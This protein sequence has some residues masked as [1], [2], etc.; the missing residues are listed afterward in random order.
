[1]ARPRSPT[2]RIGRR[3]TRSIHA[4]AGKVKRM[5]GRNS[6]VPSS[7]NWKASTWRT[8]AA[9]NGIAN[10]LICDPKTLID[11]A[12]HSLRKLAWRQRDEPAIADAGPRG[13]LGSIATDTARPWELAGPI[14]RGPAGGWPARSRSF[15][16]EA[17]F[18]DQLAM[19]IT[20]RK[21]PSLMML[22]AP[23]C[24]PCSFWA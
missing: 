24:R 23:T 1:M 2:M 18:F 19:I 3:R 22:I 12:V 4:P 14:A 8:R 10:A 5:K 16:P 11:W 15:R 9:T 21:P 7:A 20:G 6:I 13:E 17:H